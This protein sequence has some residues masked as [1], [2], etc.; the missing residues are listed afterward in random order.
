MSVTRRRMP[1]QMR[2]HVFTLAVGV[3][4]R[5]K[6]ECDEPHLDVLSPACDMPPSMYY[7]NCICHD[8]STSMLA[9]PAYN[10]AHSIPPFVGSSWYCDSSNDGIVGNSWSAEHEMFSET[11][12]CVN[13]EMG[14]AALWN[15]L[16]RSPGEWVS[17]D[18]PP[19]TAPLEI[20][21]LTSRDTFYVCKLVCMHVCMCFCTLTRM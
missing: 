20:R 8:G 11:S 12:T 6:I 7:G 15:R 2:E 19:S 9:E 1:E 13:T 4:R 17:V 18:L 14:T 5:I 21:L 16:S 3:S 10:P